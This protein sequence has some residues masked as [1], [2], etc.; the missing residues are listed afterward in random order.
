MRKYIYAQTL[1]DLMSA[2]SRPAREVKGTAR[3]WLKNA[4]DVPEQMDDRTSYAG[5]LT[6]YQ[7]QSLHGELIDKPVGSIR[8]K[9]DEIVAWMKAADFEDRLLE[10]LEAQETPKRKEL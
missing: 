3:S 10:Q 2:T 8:G 7:L 4:I 5:M 1:L 9:M 6:P